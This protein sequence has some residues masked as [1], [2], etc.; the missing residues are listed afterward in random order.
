MRTPRSAASPLKFA[1]ACAFLSL[2]SA[3]NGV[4]PT[5][6]PA[7]DAPAPDAPAPDAPAPDASV[8][9][10]PAADRPPVDGGAGSCMRN[11]DCPRGQVCE[12][13]LGCDQTVGECHND[14]CHS[15]P[16]APQYCGCDGRT[17]QQ[18]SACLPDRPY[19]TRAPCPDAGATPDA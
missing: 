2:G 19:R 8:A 18:V 6:P 15:L 10:V 16:V 11:D 4:A 17:I 7:P 12:F 9:D 14:G 3:C 5:A 1:L 13:T